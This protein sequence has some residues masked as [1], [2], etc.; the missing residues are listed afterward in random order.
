MSD[1]GVTPDSTVTCPACGAQNPA[2]RAV[3]GSCGSSLL[4][5]EDTEGQRG[6][7]ELD[8]VWRSMAVQGYEVEMGPDRGWIACPMCGH[9]FPPRG[10]AVESASEAR[11]TRRNLAELVVL[12]LRCPSCGT[13]GR[14]AA[15]P[16]QLELAEPPETVEARDASTPGTP[17]GTGEVPWRRP[18]KPG[19]TPDR[20]L[21]DDRRFFVPV[22]DGDTTSLRERGP[23]R[24]AD[25]EDIRQYTG[26]P[27]ETEE[28]V[29]IPQQQ[30]AGPGNVAGGGEWP[31]PD[32][33]PAQPTGGDRRAGDPSAAADERR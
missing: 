10:P 13:R 29:V 32:A 3:C 8:E 20:P 4:A 33:P 26:E 9:R 31:D 15:L 28:G 21:G 30:N 23:L 19:A 6:D 11:D 18:G 14:L 16:E 5:A 25:G 17:V 24:D 1:L 2:S 7:L 22:P 12:A 27:V